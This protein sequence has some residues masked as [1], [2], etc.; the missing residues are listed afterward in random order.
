RF[1]QDGHWQWATPGEG[2]WAGNYFL[3]GYWVLFTAAV[4]LSRHEQF[5][6][7][8]RAT[9]LSVNNGAFFAAFIL[10]MLQVHHGGFWKFSLIYGAVLLGLAASALKFLA[11]D[12]LSHNTYLT[13]GL[14]LVTLGFLTYFTGF[15]LSLV[16][17]VESVVLVALGQ[18]LKSRVMQVASLAAAALAAGWAA[19]S[20]EPFDNTGLLTGAAVGAMMLLNAFLLRREVAFEQSA[21][22]LRTIFYTALAVLMGLIT[23]W[24]NAT[25]EWRGFA[26]AVESA[27]FLVAARPLGNLVMKF[28]AYFFA[29][30]AV[31]WELL[32]LGE[33]LGV[34]DVHSRVGLAPAAL[35]GALLIF[36]ALWERRLSPAARSSTFHPPVTFYSLLG[37]ASW[38][39]TTCVFTP[40]EYLAPLLALEG[41]LFTAAY[42]PLRLAE[43]P[44][45]GQFFLLFA[46]SFW[47]FDALGGQAS[48]PWWNPASTIAITLG[49]A[50]WW[51]RQKT[52]QL[53][54]P[55]GRYLQALYALAIVGLLYFWLEPRFDAPVWLAFTSLL[56]I[57]LTAYGA[58]SR[59]WFVAATGQVFLAVSIWQFGRQILEGKPEWFLPLAPIVAL[60]LLSLSAIEWFRRKPEAKTEI[61]EP[62]L[63]IGQVYRVLA[64]VMSLWWIV[65]YIPPR[66]QFWV[67]ALAGLVL[68]A[69]A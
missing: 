38:L 4:F 52:L 18:M 57:L 55:V 33:Q 36:N 67:F 50:Q 56:A 22:N 3:I 46:Q 59:F 19:A 65:K 25:P 39:L 66:E 20:I 28:G 64:L 69:L 26:L 61:R 12:K 17:A 21:S 43:L 34:F 63:Q 41:L 32:T 10:T 7:S 51:Q 62:L 8:R 40:R 42:Y 6:G 31:V 45:F 35:L 44:L 1:Y 54:E 30:V 2:L 49:L 11:A 37:L 5:S 23:T 24:Q 60:G 48:R 68:F 9:F 58:F 15:K 27:A 16:L 53:K 13:Q 14:L 47:L 29:G